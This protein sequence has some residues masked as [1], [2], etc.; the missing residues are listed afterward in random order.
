[1]YVIQLL[2][3][4]TTGVEFVCQRLK[5][6]PLIFQHQPHRLLQLLQSNDG[7][8]HCYITLGRYLTNIKT[9]MDLFMNVRWTD[10]GLR[11]I[12]RFMK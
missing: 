3:N 1:M 11:Q 9:Y 7:Q 8:I 6:S 5:F 12:W 4:W 10:F 2:C